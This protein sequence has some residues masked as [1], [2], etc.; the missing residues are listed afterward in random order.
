[1]AHAAGHPEPFLLDPDIL[2]QVAACLWK[3]GYRSLD[4]YVNAAKQQL[5]LEHGTLPDAF[6]I[7]LRRI[8]RAAARGRGPPKQAQEL[9]FERLC[10]LGEHMSPP[11]PGGPCFATRLLVV[12]IWWLL[13]EIEVSNLTIG[14]T[15][16][17]ASSA[18]LWLPSSKTDTQGEGTSRALSCTC[19]TPSRVW[20]PFHTLHSQVAW[21][22][23][24]ALRQGRIVS[25]FPLFP[26]A[27]GL[28]PTK[29]AV[30]EVIRASAASLGLPVVNEAG[31]HRYSGHTCRVTGAMHLASSGIDVWRIQLHGRWGSSSVLRYIRL[32]PLASTLSQEAALG[33]D[34]SQVQGKLKQAKLQ[35]AQAQVSLGAAAT[36]EAVEEIMGADLFEP[37]GVLGKLS[38]DDLLSQKSGW[39]RTPEEG[40]VLLVNDNTARLH[41]LRPPLLNLPQESFAEQL[42]GLQESQAKTWCGW[43]VAAAKSKRQHTQSLAAWSPALESLGQL[44]P[45]CFGRHADVETSSSSSSGVSE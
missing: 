7:H 30:V 41:S 35:L 17:T 12:A 39:H 14:C 21:A 33:K 29:K 13:R 36:D 32:S 20:C 5:I 10:E 2:Y 40:E 18:A 44:C 24:E 11:V 15:S 3:A 9:P 25:S 42:T 23:E 38:V 19:V 4:S 8:S 28:A 16:F 43:K 27:A 1:M 26:T 6:N 34:L 31:F 45:K 22:S 37:V